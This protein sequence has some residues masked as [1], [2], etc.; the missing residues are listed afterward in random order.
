[1]LYSKTAKYA[2]LALAEV[3]AREA[4]G[5][6]ATRLIAEAT[7]SPY[8]LLAKIVNQLHR[9]GL[10]KASRGKQGGIRLSRSASEMT[11][12]DVVVALDG[13][14]ILNDCPLFLEPCNCDRQCSLHAIWK[15]ARD[16]VVQFLE[17]TTIQAVADARA[18]LARSEKQ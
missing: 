12:K 17:A 11:I 9:A 2:V 13:A 15:P 1:M 6:V 3:A 10:V 8:P 18:G 7:A 5:L 14:A 4:E 16:A